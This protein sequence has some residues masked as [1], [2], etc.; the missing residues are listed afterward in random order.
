MHK[1]ELSKG[2]E[3]ELNHI[4]DPKIK[5]ELKEIISAYKPKKTKTVDV[6]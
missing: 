5:T 4:H 1:S 6:S 2:N 3:V